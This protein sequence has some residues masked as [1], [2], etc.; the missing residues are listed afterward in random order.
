MLKQHR[1]IKK[2]EGWKKAAIAKTGH[3]KEL[4]I[5][6]KQIQFTYRKLSSHVGGGGRREGGEERL[7]YRNHLIFNKLETAAAAN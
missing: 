2:I 3:L 6:K 4:L 5:S 7:H 1:Q